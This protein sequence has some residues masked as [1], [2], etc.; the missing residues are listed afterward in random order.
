VNLWSLT[1]WNVTKSEARH[2]CIIVSQQRQS[3]WYCLCSSVFICNCLCL[4]VVRLTHGGTVFSTSPFVHLP[5]CPSIPFVRSFVH[6]SA[7]KLMNTIF[8]EQ[9][10]WVWCHLAQVDYWQRHD[11]INFAGTGSRRLRSHDA[12]DRFRGLAEASFFTTS[13]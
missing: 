11:T 9:M 7:N 2:I 12:K 8:W 3:L 13:G 10:N 4:H 5:R 1:G 6:L